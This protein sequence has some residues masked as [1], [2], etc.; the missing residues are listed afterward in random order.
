MTP[1]LV[2]SHSL[3][4]K[5]VSRFGTTDRKEKPKNLVEK[6]GWAKRI[7]GFQAFSK[8]QN[9][10]ENPKRQIDPARF[11]RANCP[12]PVLLFGATTL[13]IT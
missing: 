12:L 8:E 7:H 11:V 3:R 9:A 6:Y 1:P 10:R 5:F 2:A 13:R 4:F